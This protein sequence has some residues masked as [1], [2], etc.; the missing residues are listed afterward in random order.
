VRSIPKMTSAAPAPA[1]VAGCLN[2]QKVFETPRP[3]SITRAGV[4]P[5]IPFLAIIARRDFPMQRD[6]R[7]ESSPAAP[8]L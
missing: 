5:P 3:R 4:D 1:L 8:D 2:N 7:A 6:C